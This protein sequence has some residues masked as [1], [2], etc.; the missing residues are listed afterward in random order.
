MS[1]DRARIS[2]DERRRYRSV[3]TQQ[4]RV[5]L[6]AD[7]NE[8]RT[9]AAENLR[10]ETLDVVGPNGTPDNGFWVEPQ[11][12]PTNPPYDVEIGPGTLYVGGERV[13][14][15]DT[16]WYSKQ[17]EW[18]DFEG[19]PAWVDPGEPADANA[20]NEFVYLYLEEHEVGAVEDGALFEVALGGPDSAQRMRLLQRIRRLGTGAATCA[21]AV[22]AAAGAW[23]ADGLQL[24][25]AS[26]RLLSD[27]TLE[28]SY[29]DPGTSGDLC[30]PDAQG[31]YLGAD[32]Q[33]IRVEI[34]A[35]G[36]A[37]D[38]PQLLWGYDNASFL[39][40]VTV[41]AD[42]Q[43]LTLGSVPVDD[44]HKPRSGQAVEVLRAAASLETGWDS[45]HEVSAGDFVAA[46]TGD[47]QTLASDYDSDTQQ[48]VLPS[49]L[50]AE[51]GDAT[52]SPAV[53]VRVW[54]EEL[55]FTPG[56]AVDLG[57]TGVS[58]TIETTGSFH[59]GDFWQIGV[60]PKTPLAVYPERYLDQPQPPDGPRLWASPLAV[61]EWSDGV[62]SV[63]EDCRNP[64][65]NLVELTKRR[66]SGCCDI[67]VRPEDMTAAG[68]LQ[69]IVDSFAGTEATICLASGA[70]VLDAPL[71]LGPQHTGL[72]IEAC[73]GDALISAAAGAEEKFVD[74]LIVLAR[75]NEITLRGLRLELP[76]VPFGATKITLGGKEQVALRAQVGNQLSK[77]FLSVGVRAVQS[78][79]LVVE[80]CLFQFSTT[81]DQDVFG[82]GLFLG[83]ECFGL[84]VQ[85]STF[86]SDA[87]YQASAKPRLRVTIGVLHAPMS[88]IAGAGGTLVQARLEDARFRDNH[89][90]GLTV[91][92]FLYADCGVIAFEDNTVRLTEV[93]FLVVAQGTIAFS[94]VAGVANAN[95]VGHAAAGG[96]TG[97][98]AQALATAVKDPVVLVTAYLATAYP[99][100]ADAAAA[101][102]V[103][104]VNKAEVEKAVP[105]ESTPVWEM[106]ERANTLF[107]DTG[108]AIPDEKKLKR[109]EL[110]FKL[111]A[112]H[113]AALADEYLELARI[114]RAALLKAGGAAGLRLSLRAVGNEIDVRVAEVTSGP[115]L[116]VWDVSREE[117]SALV[118]DANRMASQSGLL[119]TVVGLFLSHSAVA[120]NVIENSSPKGSSII[121][122]PGGATGAPAY[123]EPGISVA[124]NVLVGNPLLPPRSL[125]APLDTWAV[126]NSVNVN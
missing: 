27:A 26:Q 124:G 94:S 114:E 45:V 43:T 20:A 55:P 34:A 31:G 53:F 57:T 112:A 36:D 30:E 77:I 62:L 29:K 64:F 68:S 105:A 66:Q 117:D 61:V 19:D 8:D 90:S 4:G 103:I 104:A 32:N 107:G 58:V 7:S 23:A 86:A 21:D 92:A 83:G 121:L 37:E 13:V 15:G 116:L 95:V 126:F 63:L 76:R 113:L 49:A 110:S 84:T 97:D 73:H 51:Y 28:V 3:V 48:I 80:N 99:W 56:T 100:P 60:R 71:R 75:A 46:S 102:G 82:A 65:D 50:P 40:R 119:G 33:L 17:D 2:Y 87:T 122:V 14:L 115:A 72:T 88:T 69:A 118:I 39:Y 54:E 85:G 1:S 22:A 5:T 91:A 108:A 41:G 52:A 74:G 125:P 44:S 12:G 47:V 109:A 16:L 79:L 35:A 101:A 78:S 123:Q 25:P 93:G 24:D 89:F 10:A 6:E 42:L 81:A 111:S 59:V 70:Y 106:V 38:E 120:G 67:L 11:P 9:I 18:L 98:V 96:F